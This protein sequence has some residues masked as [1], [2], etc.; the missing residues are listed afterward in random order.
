MREGWKK[1]YPHPEEWVS[2]CLTVICF[3]RE[4]V[5]KGSVVVGDKIGN[6]AMSGR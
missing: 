6:E 3:V 1:V 5:A 4:R 2:R